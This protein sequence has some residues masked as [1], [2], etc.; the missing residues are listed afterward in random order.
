VKKKKPFDYK[1][2][3]RE[4]NARWITTLDTADWDLDEYG[5]TNEEEL[6]AYFHAYG[7]LSFEMSKEHDNETI[8]WGWCKALLKEVDCLRATQQGRDFNE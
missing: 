5:R 1:S 8:L 3:R 7:N 2:A 6:R 4:K